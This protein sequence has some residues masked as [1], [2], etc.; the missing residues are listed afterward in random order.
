MYTI[1]TEL[2]E[3]VNEQGQYKN[4]F[5]RSLLNRDELSSYVGTVYA[6]LALSA[7]GAI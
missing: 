1:G 4:A 7:C 2:Q 6:I 3:I 5:R